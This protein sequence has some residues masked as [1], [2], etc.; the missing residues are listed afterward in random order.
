[1][2][3]RKFHVIFLGPNLKSAVTYTQILIYYSTFVQ[4]NVSQLQSFRD[5]RVLQ[6]VA[7]CCSVLQ[8]VAMCTI[9][10]TLHLSNGM[11]SEGSVASYIKILQ[12]TATHCN[13]LQHTAT[14]CITSQHVASYICFFVCKLPRVAVC[15]N[16]L[17]CV[18]VCCDTLQCVYSHVPFL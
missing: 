14:H 8:C 3:P 5:Q 1:M 12:H 11:R 9:P 15:C 17:Q 10:R 4:T 16:V 2:G 6:R 18:A 13:T 7:V